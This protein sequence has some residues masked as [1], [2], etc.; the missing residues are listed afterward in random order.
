MKDKHYKKLRESLLS[1]MS[2]DPRFDVF[3]TE[4]LSD[5]ICKVVEETLKENEKSLND[6]I[7]TMKENKALDNGLDWIKNNLLN[8]PPPRGELHMFVKEAAEKFNVEV[9]LMRRKAESS[10]THTIELV[11]IDRY[12]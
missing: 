2:T 3:H 5:N 6:K 1:Y 11:D 8:S 9:D 7:S 10:I 12:C 4:T